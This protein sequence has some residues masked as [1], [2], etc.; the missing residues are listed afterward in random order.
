LNQART[1]CA[2][3]NYW[4]VMPPVVNLSG[5]KCEYIDRANK[6]IDLKVVG[7]IR[8]YGNLKTERATE[9]EKITARKVLT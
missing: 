1:I 9:I 2:E 6:F 4:R 8:R 5:I 7:K 3:H